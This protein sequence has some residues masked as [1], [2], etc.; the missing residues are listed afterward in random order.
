MVYRRHTKTHSLVAIFSV[1]S[2]L[3][4]P[5]AFML[6]CA[7]RPPSF[8]VRTSQAPQAIRQLVQDKPEYFTA[9]LT[10][11]VVVDGSQCPKALRETVLWKD[12]KETTIAAGGGFAFATSRADSVGLL[13]TMQLDSVEAPVLV[14]PGCERNLA[15]LG[16]VDGVIP[17]KLLVNRNGGIHFVSSRAGEPEQSE[18]LMALVDS[19][20][21]VE[22]RRLSDPTQTDTSNK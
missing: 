14:L 8:D 11:V 7:W 6:G 4:L 20:C 13:W 19:L 5:G 18:R 22:T 10:L 9:P 16:V 1:I 21:R 12:W 3:L 17:M 15:E 2:A